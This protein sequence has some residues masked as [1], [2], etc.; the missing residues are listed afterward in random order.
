MP[1]TTT[2]APVQALID[3][4]NRGDTQAFLGC[5]TPDGVVD[6][7]GRRFLGRDAIRTWS[8]TEFIGVAV[9]LDVIDVVVDGAHVTLSAEV[10]GNG[11]T[12]PSTFDF[13]LEADLVN[14]MSISA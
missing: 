2:P 1:T 8:N 10:G 7:W 11:F 5:F 12:G 13:T 6:D 3:A 4:A 9:S 14:R